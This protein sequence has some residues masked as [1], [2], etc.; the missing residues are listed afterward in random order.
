MV[1]P[2]GLEPT[3]VGL[4][5]RCAT[6]TPRAEKQKNK[7]ALDAGFKAALPGLLN[8]SQC[9]IPSELLRSQI[10]SYKFVARQRLITWM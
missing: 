9:S 4:K 10:C 1:R 2:V 8:T 3:P 6:I 7:L 5:G